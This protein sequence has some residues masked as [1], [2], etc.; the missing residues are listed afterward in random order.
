LDSSTPKT[1]TGVDV[2]A[3]RKQLRRVIAVANRALQRR[4][5]DTITSS[6]S[7]NDHDITCSASTF[8][9]LPSRRR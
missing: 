7:C 3:A 8:F 1:R 4:A 6:L 9:V 2:V 5:G